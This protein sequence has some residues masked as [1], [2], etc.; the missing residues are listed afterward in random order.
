MR[1]DGP[2]FATGWLS[3][4]QASSR[5]K[6]LATLNRTVA[7]EEYFNGFRLVAT[8]RYMLLTAWIPNDEAATSR[9]P[10]LAEAPDRTVIA[11]DDDGRGRS[12]LG[13]VLSLWHREGEDY[14][15][16]S[17]VLDVRFDVRLPAGQP[18]TQET[19]E[20]LE[21]LYVVFDVPDTERVHLPI[22]G[23]AFPDWRALLHA[24]TPETTN[25]LALNPELV[26]R[27]A[28]VRKW[29]EGNL[30]WEFGGP[31]RVARVDY[32][33]SDPH[34]SGLVMPTRWVMDGEATDNDDEQHDGV[35]TTVSALAD[36]L[37]PDADLLRQAAE[38]VISTQFGSTAML[39][40]KLRVG[41]AKA[42]RLM[43]ILEQNSI[44]GPAEG[45]KARE[46][47]VEPAQLDEAITSMLG[48]DS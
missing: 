27:V 34:V 29:S 39:Q 31:D 12:L 25:K 21:P 44:V 13:Y 2:T 26:E 42:G 19:L 15:D 23:D 9:E 7:I 43:D 45:S 17:L 16:G 48:D 46:V 35:V 24:F 1:F 3:V 41:F 10:T 20:G 22:V 18:G 8:D 4:A 6:L 30:H 28:K 37:L 38:L 11:R 14:I 40:R 33:S 5:D 36:A 32:Q 47:L